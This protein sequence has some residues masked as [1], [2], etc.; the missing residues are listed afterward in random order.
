MVHGPAAGLELLGAL[1]ADSR[2][3]GHHRA[4]AVRAHLLEMAGNTLDAITHYSTAAGR[5]TSLPERNYLLTQVARLMEVSPRDGVAGL[6]GL[7]YTVYRSVVGEHPPLRDLPVANH[8]LP[9]RRC[10][11]GDAISRSARL[12]CCQHDFA[13]RHVSHASVALEL[14]N[15]ENVILGRD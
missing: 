10:P 15:L 1:A 11:P 2:M 4:D 12:A 5:T 14:E 6:A 8:R 9:R 7:S 3:A 13:F